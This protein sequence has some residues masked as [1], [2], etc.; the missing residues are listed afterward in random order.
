MTL[1]LFTVATFESGYMNELKQSCNNN[2]I[3]I[4]DLK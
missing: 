4:T 2:N 1:I 3:S